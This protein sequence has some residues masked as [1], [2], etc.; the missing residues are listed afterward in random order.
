MKEYNYPEATVGAII[1]NPEDKVF[2][3]KTHKWNDQYAIPGGHIEFGETME[4]AIK[5]EV[6]EETNLDIFDIEFF[7]AIDC[8]FSEEF[9]TPNRHFIFLDFIAKTKSSEVILNEEAQEYIW[10][11]EQE[12]KDLP[13][14]EPTREIIEKYF[15][16]K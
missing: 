11:S 12:L 16:V 2:L 10:A 6:K 8:I 4:D 14:F 7:E 15:S 3:M 13:I 9:H 5:R 1:I